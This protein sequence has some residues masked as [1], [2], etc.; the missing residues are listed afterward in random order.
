MIT[1]IRKNLITSRIFKVIVWGVV[2]VLVGSLG[3]PVFLQQKSPMGSWA[4]LVN[5]GTVSGI[6]FARKAH[7]QETQLELFRQQFGAQAD[8]LLRSMGI[9]AHP[10]DLALDVVIRE[11]LLN[12]AASAMKIAV[13]PDYAAKKMNDFNFVRQ[14]LSDLIPYSAM[15]EAG[16]SMAHV[17]DYLR[18]MQLSVADF[19]V[20]V[21]EAVGRSQVLD[22]VALT[23]YV[24]SFEKNELLGAE[25]D[26]KKFSFITISFDD[27]LAQA[28]KKS[29]TDAE[30]RTFFDTENMRS[31]RYIVPEQRSGISWQFTAAGYGILIDDTMV[32]SYYH[33]HKAE[34]FV[35][36]EAQVQVRRILFAVRDAR[37][38][39]EVFTAIQ[40]LRLDLAIEPNLF[41]KKAEEL[42][43][44]SVTKKQGG[45]MAP[46]ARGTQEPSF[47]RAAFLLERDGDISS[48]VE[49]PQG[50][51]LLQRV[52]KTPATFKPLSAVKKE[53]RNRLEKEAFTKQFSQD[54][55]RIVAQGGGQEALEQLA[56]AKGAKKTIHQDLKMGSSD[57][58]KI[59]FSIAELG[60]VASKAQETSGM[61]VVLDDIKK[62]H[63][64]DLA[65]VKD[66]VTNDFYEQKAHKDM[67]S[68]ASHMRAALSAKKSLQEVAAEYKG[69]LTTTGYLTANNESSLATLRAQGLPVEEMVRMEKVGL[70][71]LGKGKKDMYLIRLNE[72]AKGEVQ[73]TD[74][75]K[76]A[77]EHRIQQDRCRMVEKG[78]VA[79]LHRN[80]T[81]KINQ[82]LINT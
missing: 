24:P 53:I 55:E 27:A 45:L 30:L 65:S 22:L 4:V 47:D 41:A 2:A 50:F 29:V 74:A 80:A 78:F 16:I 1:L 42:S 51:E 38:R 66:T 37:K 72:I 26:S 73:H 46:F 63:T 5:G 54:I 64:P 7:D 75:E 44:D 19:E 14:E 33:A 48:I 56:L 15:T 8:I 13:H 43:D 57:S 59:L 60:G 69:A 31:Q 35:E 76:E 12:Q 61:A 67:Q 28:K 20:R 11:E 21:D 6:D 3:V 10:K 70:V 52:S 34:L 62:A 77:L 25:K 9:S 40:K 79:S 68:V 58:A 36:A 23:N 17:S 49:T 81:I 18:R 71:M 39:Q 82:S 32:E